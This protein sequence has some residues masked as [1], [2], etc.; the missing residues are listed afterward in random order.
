M[1]RHD[2][3]TLYKQVKECLMKH[4]DCENCIGL[5]KAKFHARQEGGCGYLHKR[6]PIYKLLNTLFAR[7]NIKLHIKWKIRRKMKR[8][9]KIITQDEFEKILKFTKKK[10]L[11]VAFLL[12]FESGLRISEI[13]GWKDRVPKLVKE[14]VDLQGHQIR[15]VSGKGKKDRIVP[16][17]KRFD[18]KCWK[19]LPLKIKR[20]TL[21]YQIGVVSERAIGKK[22]NFHVLRHGFANHLVNECNMPISQVQVLLGHSRLDTTGVYLHAN[23]KAATEKAR[24]LF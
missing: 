19:M 9:P 24:E 2:K 3:L 5:R 23:P 16:L 12:G 18:V 6:Y 8:L 15:V 7:N 13:V 10:T 21:Q 1:E 14:N 17:P 20:R 11:K 4:G 22:I